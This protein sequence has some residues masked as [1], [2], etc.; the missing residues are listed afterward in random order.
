MIIEFIISNVV[1]G[2]I[3]I[4]NL[5]PTLPQIPL[6]IEQAG[7]WAIATI[8]SV[9]SVLYM[10]YTKELILALLGVVIA[11]EAFEYVYRIVM[12][13]VRK[14]PLLSIH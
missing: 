1:T 8:V 12:W 11:F 7:D 14:V 4:F 13:V 3:G 2:L 10:V 5:L 9:I 6:V